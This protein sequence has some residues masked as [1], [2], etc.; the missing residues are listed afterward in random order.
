MTHSTESYRN[1]INLSFPLVLGS[2]AHTVISVTD[3]AFMG[4]IGDVAI[5]AVGLG[6]IILLVFTM[7]GIGLANGAQIIIARMDGAKDHASIGKI[8]QDVTILLLTAAVALIG[9][10][11][12]ASSS[13]VDLLIQSDAISES[14]ESYLYIRSWGFLPTFLLIAYRA[15]FTGISHTRPIAITSIVMAL[16]NVV[17]NY[18]FVFGN[19][20]CPRMGIDGAALASVGSEVLSTVVILIYLP[21]YVDKDKYGLKEKW[22]VRYAGMVRV[23]NLAIPMVLQY[24]LSL[25]SWLVFFVLIEGMGERALSVSNVVRSVY[26]ILMI[27][28]IALGNA[29]NTLVSNMIGQG[30]EDMVWVVVKRTLTLAVVG[31]LLFV[32]VNR[33][34]PSIAL[35]IFTDD[36]T[37]IQDSLP[38][39]DVISITMFFFAIGM[40]LL[41]A[42]AGTGNTRMSLFIEIAT[43]VVYLTFI[44]MVVHIYHW[45][46]VNVW[47][48]ELVYFSLLSGMSLAYLW[49]GK[50]KGKKI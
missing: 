8:Y 25:S 38:I 15:F 4:R 21:L 39:I 29:V 20:G 45:E 42:V 2:M 31:S 30:K 14:V 7:T 28:N 41:S 12:V 46:L 36:V 10:I 24:F 1:I 50:W 34:D 35:S 26:S 43:L 18:M 5:G 40:I 49:S 11:H 17:F 6:G 44:Y 32:V 16:S 19:W 13:L 3:T 48:A 27:P 23:V 47:L 22:K 37:L 9:F 33:I